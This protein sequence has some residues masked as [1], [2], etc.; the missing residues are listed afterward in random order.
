MATGAVTCAERSVTMHGPSGHKIALILETSSQERSSLRTKENEA[1]QGSIE[2]VS[3]V[4]RVEGLVLIR[5]R[6]NGVVVDIGPM[7]PT[8]LWTMI[9]ELYI[10]DKYDLSRLSLT[11]RHIRFSTFHCMFRRLSFRA[12][13]TQRPGGIREYF[14]YLVH[15]I[16]RIEYLHRSTRVLPLVQSVVV[17]NWMEVPRYVPKCDILEHRRRASKNDELNVNYLFLLPEERKILH[18]LRVYGY[19]AIIDFLAD[20]PNLTEVRFVENPWF[21]WRLSTQQARLD[22][23]IM[24]RR[25]RGIDLRFHLS[26][27]ARKTSLRLALP[28]SIEFYTGERYFAACIPEYVADLLDHE[29]II[30]VDATIGVLDFNGLCT[31]L[32]EMQP[33]LHTLQNFTVDIRLFDSK[34]YEDIHRILESICM[35]ASS[36][37]SLRIDAWAEQGKAPFNLP[38]TALP[39]LE[40]VSGRPSLLS[41]LI[42]G[43][44]VDCIRVTDMQWKD[45]DAFV[46]S[47]GSG[48][49]ADVLSLDIADQVIPRKALQ[50]VADSFPRLNHLSIMQPPSESHVK[51]GVSR[52]IDF[53]LHFTD[54][55]D[56]RLLRAFSRALYTWC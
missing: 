15:L 1:A 41:N 45:D 34:E 40:S 29:D 56:F 14:G 12:F 4:I 18:S 52:E 6:P 30:L 25:F 48:L 42:E 49:I 51:P 22:R 3:E 50:F 7:L 36:L 8:E 44:P 31:I 39:L 10:A 16:Q 33:C 53:S 5:R 17:E 13:D 19:Q 23:L 37:R 32:D 28:P 35:E 27:W 11:S 21:I 38:P 43:R 26:T 24:P 2:Q 20:L 47:L 9:A 46:L 55:S 54:R